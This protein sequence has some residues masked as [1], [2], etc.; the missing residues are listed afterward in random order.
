MEAGGWSRSQKTAQPTLSGIPLVLGTG[1]R[2]QDHW[3]D[4]V[5]RALAPWEKFLKDD[6]PYLCGGDGEPGIGSFHTKVP[7]GAQKSRG[8]P[9]KI[10]QMT[11]Q[12]V[13]G[14]SRLDARMCGRGSHGSSENLEQKC[15]VE[16]RGEP[17]SV[18]RRG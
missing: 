4:V 3:V 15:L 13:I 1:T 12:S 9:Q 7:K 8:I 6:Y 10:A 14:A 11:R 18:V 16:M 2:M 5:F 17:R